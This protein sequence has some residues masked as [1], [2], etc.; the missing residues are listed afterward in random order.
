M[1]IPRLSK[2]LG[3]LHNLETDYALV[4]QTKH[5]RP[6][7][8]PIVPLSDSFLLGNSPFETTHNNLDNDRWYPQ[9]QYQYEAINLICQCGPGT[10]KLNG[11]NTV[12][13]KGLYTFYFKFGGSPPPMSFVDDPETQDKYAIPN[14]MLKTTSL[15]SPGTPLQTFLYN[16]DTKRDILTKQATKRLQ[17]DWDTKRLLFT[18]GTT[19]STSTVE[20]VSKEAQ[21]ESSEEE[22]EEEILHLL[23][24]QH[25]YQR[26]LRHR[27][28]QLMNQ[29]QNLE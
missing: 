4:I 19:K 20:V 29:M 12:E 22:K 9:L 26:E 24:Q 1:G 13:A 7:R 21:E 3:K 6:I 28:K 11:K 18:D 10:P 25:Q 27:I 23:K 16:F 2:K 17:K 5:T 8:S 14:N 15:Q